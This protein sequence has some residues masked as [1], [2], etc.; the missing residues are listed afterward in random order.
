MESAKTQLNEVMKTIQVMKL[1][2]NKENK[3]KPN[4]IQNGK[5][6]QKVRQKALRKLSPIDHHIKWNREYQILRTL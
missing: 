3:E 1:E 5:K 6:A 4:K 2:F